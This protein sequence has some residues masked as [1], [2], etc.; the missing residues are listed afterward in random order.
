M[1]FP[2]FLFLFLLIPVPIIFHF[3]SKRI[4]RNKDFPSLLFV[5]KSDRRLLR[6]FHL[7]RLLLLLLRVGV[8]VSLIFSASNLLIPLSFNEPSKTIILDRSLSMKELDISSHKADVIVPNRGG[9]SLIHKA[10]KL[11]PIGILI[12]DAQRNGFIKLLRGGKSYP[13]IDLEKISL[14]KGNIAIKDH[15]I[16]SPFVGEEVDIVFT[17]LNQYKYSKTVPFS[18]YIDDKE[19]K[20]KDVSLNQGIN[21]I[22]FHLSLPEGLHKGSLVV[23]DKGGFE[24]DNIRYFTLCIIPK[25]KV[26]IYSSMNPLKL[27]AALNSSSFQVK[28]SKGPLIETEGDI[29][30]VDDFPLETAPNSIKGSLP[31]IICFSGGVKSPLA[32]EIPYK[33]S[34]IANFPVFSPFGKLQTICNIPI[35]Y[36][37]KLNRGQT[38]LYFENGDA[39]LKR[40]G[41]LFFLPISLDESD[42]SLHP[43]YVP[44]L[45]QLIASLL[46]EDFNKD[47]L[48][49][50]VVVIKAPFKPCVISPEGKRYFTDSIGD[51]RYLFRQT[52]RPGIYGVSDG[53]GIRGYISVN[54]DP[55]EALLDTLKTQEIVTLFGKEGYNNGTTFFLL[56]GFLFF[57]LSVLLE[58][59]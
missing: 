44:F 33:V 13:G 56:I 48:I 24:F 35:R 20:R 12:S 41:N 51:N 55:T 39:F 27:L 22:S 58:R 36:N 17:L 32:D 14:P 25:T 18:L 46:K 37:F 23:Y 54:P 28:W 59:K 4:L 42:L 52:G 40:E 34:K 21:E 16:G 11:H 7:K 43:V 9:I 31:G 15:Q 49:D 57:V 29:F 50:Q 53:T 10:L 2:Q 47:I 30:V 45:Y 3:I 1:S 26:V 6:W 8:I 5:L 19:L 38:L